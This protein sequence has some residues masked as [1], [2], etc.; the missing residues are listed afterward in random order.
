MGFL[1]RLLGRGKEAAESA[2]DTA[3]D[4]G[5]NAKEEFEEAE[6]R[7]T[8]DETPEAPQ[9]SE[10]SEVSQAEQRL[11]DVRDQAARDEG[12]MP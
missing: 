3:K 4:L 9:A 6:D 8:G 2:G 10:G 5:E 11:D 7:V 12:R 1:D